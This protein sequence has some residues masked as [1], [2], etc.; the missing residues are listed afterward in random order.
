MYV[1]K[2]IVCIGLVLLTAITVVAQKF[3]VPDS[4][5]QELEM[6][7]IKLED[8]S[9]IQYKVHYPPNFDSTKTYPAYLCLSGGDQ[10]PLIVDYCYYAYFRTPQ[11]NDYITILPIAQALFSSKK[12]FRAYT[13]D[14][15]KNLVQHIQKHEPLTD[16]GWL[17]GGSSN[18]G[19]GAFG[20]ANAMPELFNGMIVMPGAINETMAANEKWKDYKVLIAVGSKDSAFW[21]QG[22]KRSQNTLK[23][24]VKNVQWM[25]LNGEEHI[26]TPEFDIEKIYTRYFQLQ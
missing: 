9:T 5:K 13:N 14:E 16:T 26:L 25:L 19:I 18:G 6:K 23:G 17:L 1:M 15:V 7:T 22:T 21:L 20:F 10:G 2:N 3:D 12:N 4:I 11:V 24:N 8:G